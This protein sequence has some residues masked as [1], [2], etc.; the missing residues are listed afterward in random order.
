MSVRELAKSSSLAGNAA[1]VIDC[2]T[3]GTTVLQLLAD[4]RIDQIVGLAVSHNHEDHAGGASS[5]LAQYEGKIGT[6]WLLQDPGLL[7][8]RFLGTIKQQISDETLLVSQLCRLEAN[9]TPKLLFSDSAKEIKL[10]LYSPSTGQNLLTQAAKLSNP[11]SAIIGLNVHHRSLV[12]AADS[13][14]EQWQALHARR[15]KPLDCDVLGVSHHGGDVNADPPELQRLYT[16]YIRPKTAVISVGTTNRHD[17]PRQDV[18]QAL[19]AAGATVVCTQITKKCCRNLERLRPGVL[20]T[21]KHVG[22]SQPDK[23]VTSAGN[24]KNVACFSTVLVQVDA[25]GVAIDGLAEHQKAVNTL[26]AS[27]KYRPLCRT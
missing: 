8:G 19:R 14:I 1:I 22:L 4:L 6:I 21:L 2:G 20:K 17:H 26:P 18:I 23:A 12:F 25:K 10:L 9:S 13:Q 24:S 7:S 5:V 3:S 11:T 16:E 15:K 27:G